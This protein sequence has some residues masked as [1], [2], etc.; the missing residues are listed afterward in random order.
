[1]A[2]LAG[3]AHSP[4]SSLGPNSEMIKCFAVGSGLVAALHF[5]LLEGY[6]QSGSA[7]AD[8]WLP[9]ILYTRMHTAQFC[10][11]LLWGFWKPWEW[12]GLCSSYWCRTN[13]ERKVRVLLHKQGKVTKSSWK[14]ILVPPRLLL[15]RYDKGPSPTWD[16]YCALRYP[17]LMLWA[18]K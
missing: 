4:R 5:Q 3:L 1:M 17:R 14:G 10:G 12:D 13:V 16:R 11:A 15:L 2:L 7:G 6:M 9:F 18:R 8:L